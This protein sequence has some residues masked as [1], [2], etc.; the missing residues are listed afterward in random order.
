MGLEVIMEDIV[1]RY[2]LCVL[3]ATRDKEELKV[4]VAKVIGIAR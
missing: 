1:N 2:T 3:V 4:L